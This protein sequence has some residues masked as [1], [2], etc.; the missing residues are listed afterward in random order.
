MKQKSRNINIGL[1]VWNDSIW[2]IR[3]KFFSD[4][5][6][7]KYPKNGQRP[8]DRIHDRFGQRTL[9]DLKN[10][11]AAAHAVYQPIQKNIKRSDDG[12]RQIA[13]PSVR[14][15]IFDDQAGEAEQRDVH[16]GHEN[17]QGD[18]ENV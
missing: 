2:N 8:I 15:D 9:H 13:D 4:E 1:V 6:S 5:G 7:R 18:M 3:K 10:G 11:G 16:F 17:E 14:A 12:Q